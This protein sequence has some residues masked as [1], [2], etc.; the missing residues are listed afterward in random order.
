MTTPAFTPQLGE[1]KCSFQA[2]VSALSTFYRFISRASKL[3]ASPSKIQNSSTK[4]FLPGMRTLEHRESSLPPSF[5]PRKYCVSTQSSFISHASKFLKRA[6]RRHYFDSLDHSNIPRTLG[7]G[8]WSFPIC[9]R[10]YL[11]C[12]F[13]P[14]PAPYPHALPGLIPVDASPARNF[15]AETATRMKS[16]LRILFYLGLLL[17]LP[18]S[19]PADW[20]MLRGTPAHTGFLS[21]S[22]PPKLGLAW[23]A[24][25]DGERLGTAVEPIVS[26]SRLFVGTHSGSL[27]ALEAETGRPLWRFQAHGPFL[28]SPAAAGDL[29]LTAC[30]DGNLY[31]LDQQDGSLRWNHLAGQGGFSAA[32]IPVGDAVYA[33]TRSGR[34]LSLEV[35]TGKVLWIHELLAPVRQTPAIAAGRLYVTAEDLRVRAFD[36]ATGALLWTSAQ[37]PGQTARDYYPVIV[38]SGDRTF[39]VV[40]TNPVLGMAQRIG[41]DRTMLCRNAGVDDSGWEKVDA[42][43]KSEASRGTPELWRK[44]QDAIR[45]YLQNTP[46]AQTFHVLDAATGELRPPSPVLWVA[47]CQAVGAQPVLTRDGRLLVFYRSAYGNWNHGVAPLVALGLLDLEQNE[48]TPLRHEQGQQPPWNTFWGTAD[49]SQNFLV[50]GDIVFI[51]H[52]GTLS[53]FDLQTSELFHIHGHRDTFGGFRTP[54]WARNEWHGPARSGIAVDSPRIFWQTGSRILCL[55][56]DAAGAKKVRTLRPADFSTRTAP[57]LRAIS[58]VQ[59]RDNLARDVQQFLSRRWAPFFLEPGLAGR[60]FSFAESREIFEALAAAY[61]HLEAPLQKD[62]RDFL[63][64]EFERVPP[65]SAEGFLDLKDG[66]PRESFSVPSEYR[67]RSGTDRRPHPFGGTYAVLGWANACQEWDRVLAA[68]PALKESY[69]AF[70]KSNWKLDGSRG[71]LYANRYISSL[72]AF[73]QIARRANDHQLAREASASADA[74]LDQLV[75]WWKRA[76]ETGTL[77]SFRDVSE[78]DPFIGRGDGLSFK[79][80]PH[81]HKVALFADLT[82]EVTAHVRQ[83]APE[84]VDAIWE[85]FEILYRTWPLQGEERQVHFGENYIDPPD[86]AL[87]AFKAMAWLRPDT[88]PHDLAAALDLPICRADLYYVQ[89]CALALAASSTPSSDTSPAP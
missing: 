84:A 49:E 6:A 9:S 29:L 81:R 10:K 8:A 36:A 79:V 16:I 54:P 40:R 78:L 48:I 87:G 37:L 25:F 63:A 7:F 11:I 77:R 82:P 64:A 88:T 66:E 53:G 43:I 1:P 50:A 35:A 62:L 55:A 28:N 24:E 70:A 18:C 65:F 67:A 74:A 32:P 69:L 14:F 13:R 12:P 45:E 75:A 89:K 39:V 3:P 22:L 26:G 46:D 31:A 59:I 80:A 44:E 76:A 38:S 23:A 73:E 57:A 72:L 61:P 71:D 15:D 27:Y 47:G 4:D 60:D 83:H 17:L 85:T 21:G 52:Q 86:L 33:A 30:S 20:P 58:S 5:H 42:W 41:R 68:Y 56:P 19:T 51:I 34:V 2:R